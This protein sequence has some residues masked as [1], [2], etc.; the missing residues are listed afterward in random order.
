[1]KHWSIQDSAC[2]ESLQDA[3]Q[4]RNDAGKFLHRPS[5]IQFLNVVRHGLDAKYPLAFGIDLQRQLAAVQ[6]EDRQIIRR[7][8][9]RHFPLGR[10]SFPAA[11]PWP[12]PVAENRFDR[13]QIQR[14]PAAVD[15]R[16]EN[17]FHPT[18]QLEQ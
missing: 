15:Q 12:A 1:M 7:F 2:H 10:L 14:C 5:T 11:V 3:L 4:L 17:S 6:P 16:L 18:A 9:D 13:V 8:L